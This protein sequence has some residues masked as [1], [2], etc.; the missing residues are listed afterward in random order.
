[1]KS[2]LLDDDNN[3][4]KRFKDDDHLTPANI[5]SSIR[6]SNLNIDLLNGIYVTQN[7][8]QHLSHVFNIPE[9]CLKTYCDQRILK[10]DNFDNNVDI[11]KN[12]E[13]EL[14]KHFEKAEVISS[15]IENENGINKDRRHIQEISNVIRS[16]WARCNNADLQENEVTHYDNNCNDYNNDSLCS[17][18]PY[19]ASIY[20][21]N[22]SSSSQ[23]SFSLTF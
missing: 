20:S 12:I 2:T 4:L 13:K 5:S 3:S 23:R 18:K 14:S 7:I 15:N 21:E 11:I 19:D 10:V 9:D 22:A 8:M 1:M 6:N 16:V 17:I